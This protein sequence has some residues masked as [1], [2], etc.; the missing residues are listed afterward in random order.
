MIDRKNV[1][2]KWKGK[3]L[4]KKKQGMNEGKTSDIVGVVGHNEVQQPNTVVSVLGRH[5]DPILPLLPSLPITI[6]RL[7]SH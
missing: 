5:L 4:F 7:G 6:V 3:S 1:K 2:K